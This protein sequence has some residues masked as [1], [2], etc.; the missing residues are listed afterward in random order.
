MEAEV[1]RSRSPTALPAYEEWPSA[2]TAPLKAKTRDEQ[3]S[4]MDLDEVKSN[5]DRTTRH[6]SELSLNEYEAVQVLESLKGGTETRMRLN[7]LR[8]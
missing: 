3:S 1:Q 7:T 2:P 8:D 5:S 6:T 4:P